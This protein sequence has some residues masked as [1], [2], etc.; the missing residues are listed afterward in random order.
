MKIFPTVVIT[1][2]DEGPLQ[3]SFFAY[4]RRFIKENLSEELSRF[5]S[6]LYCSNEGISKID[7]ENLFNWASNGD[8]KDIYKAIVEN[9]SVLDEYL[10]SII[11]GEAGWF[12]LRSTSE[13]NKTGVFPKSPNICLVFD[14]ACPVYTSLFKVLIRLNDFPHRIIVRT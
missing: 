12:S 4:F 5:V 11:S 9:D 3:S 6:S 13:A 2:Q 14:A 1:Q 8:K 10:R 7:G